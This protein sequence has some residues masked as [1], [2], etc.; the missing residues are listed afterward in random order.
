MREAKKVLGGG[1][2][3]EQR[4]YSHQRP[5]QPEARFQESSALCHLPTYSHQVQ[6][7]QVSR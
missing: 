7:S 4:T 5:S 2:V 3:V 1:P 6:W